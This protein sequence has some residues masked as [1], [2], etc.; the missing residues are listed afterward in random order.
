MTVS[1]FG[2]GIGSGSGGGGDGKVSMKE[3]AKA[4]YPPKIIGVER[5]RDRSR[6][7]TLLLDHGE[8]HIQDWAVI[9]YTTPSNNHHG[10]GMTS[11]RKKDTTWA[12]GAAAAA[13]S[14]KSKS[15]NNSKSHRSKSSRK[16]KF[17]KET[18]PSAYMTKLEG[19]LHLCSRSLVFEPSDP[20]RGIV[21]CPFSRM[22]GPPK[23]YPPH[24]LSI[25]NTGSFDPMCV[26]LESSRHLVCKVNN[27]IGPF[28]TVN[29]PTT[30]RFTFLH[31]SPVPMV[32]LCGKLF[33]ILHSKSSNT[34]L[35]VLLQPMYERPFDPTNLLDVRERPLMN[36]HLRCS[37]LQPLQCQPGCV[38]L[39]QERVYFQA[40]T[41]V[42][43]TNNK[44]QSWLQSQ[45]SATARR[46]HRLKDSALELYWKDGTST[47]LGFDRK[48]EREQVLRLLPTYIPCHTD[49]D[50]LLQASQEWQKGTITN[51]EYLLLL[52]SAAGR[53]FQD[54]SRYPVFPWVIADYESKKLDLTKESTFRDLTKPVGALNEQ[55]L[56]YFRQR[57]ESM[58]DTVDDPFFYGTHYSAAGYV[59][60]Y[61]VRSM[62]EHMLCLQNGKL[63]Y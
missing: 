27:A 11:P 43:S 7:S 35:E 56:D 21:R 36:T 10:S 52:N 30:F 8:K 25:Q 4:L 44:A 41:G 39:T 55:R 54:V 6:F 59:L 24:D 15:K 37:L 45:L 19:R 46:Y 48:H 22:P 32:E 2:S 3:A 49:R 16:Q 31:S 40:A 9:A 57:Y 62:P 17:D 26:E 34:D 38:V 14:G 63:G 33:P 51:F 28:E 53:S 23:E 60:Y 13:S 12:Q 5:G 1:W 50:F 18:Y 61:L 47:L 58:H 20:A 42:I 29:L